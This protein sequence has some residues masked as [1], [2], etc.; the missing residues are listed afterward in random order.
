MLLAADET[1]WSPSA[2]RSKRVFGDTASLLD[3][4][5]R[6]QRRGAARLFVTGPAAAQM[7]GGG[8]AGRLLYRKIK[9]FGVNMCAVALTMLSL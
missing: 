1:T 8:G 2:G 7:W 6:A 5:G 9:H 4:G 3:A